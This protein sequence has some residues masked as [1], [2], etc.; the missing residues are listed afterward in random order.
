VRLRTVSTLARLVLAGVFLVAGALKVVDARTAVQAVRAY[1]L[2][3]DSVEPLVG[4]ALPAVEIA[5]A[6][7]LAAGLF[8][9]VAAA[10]AAGL[11]VVFIAGV[12]SAAARGLSIDC[13]CFG[14]GGTVAP[15]QTRY[16]SEIVR[17]LGLLVLA[18]WLVWRPQSR[19]SLDRVE[20]EEVT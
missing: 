1:Q 7:L 19:F 3:P 9:R 8:T 17:D 16:A 4:W 14:G 6:L 20:P 15:G 5:L 11:L 12:A 18:A 2:L 10:C 13:G